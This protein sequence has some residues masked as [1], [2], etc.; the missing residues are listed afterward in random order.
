MTVGFRSAKNNAASNASTLTNTMP[1]GVAD[2][3]ALLL[4]LSMRG[5]TGSGCMIEPVVVCAATSGGGSVSHKRIVSAQ[6]GAYLY[7]SNYEDAQV[8]VV[9]TSDFVNTTDITVG[10]NPAW[11]FLSPDEANIYCFNMYGSS[12]SVIRTSDKTVVQTIS[13]SEHPYRDAAMTPDGAYLLCGHVTTGLTSLIRTS[14]GTVTYQPNVGSS[15]SGVVASPDSQYFYTSPRSASLYG[16]SRVK[17]SDG[18]VTQFT[19]GSASGTAAGVAISSDGAYVYTASSGRVQKWDTS[20]LAFH[21]YVV[22]RIEVVTA[23]ALSPD[24]STIFVGYIDALTAKISTAGSM[25]V[26]STSFQ[27]LYAMNFLFTPTGDYVWAR[28][29]Y[30]GQGSVRV[31]VSDGSSRG[32]AT[33]AT[34][35]FCWNNSSGS[36]LYANT[37]GARGIMKIETTD[38]GVWWRVGRSDGDATTLAQELFWRRALSEPASYTITFNASIYASSE[39]AAFTTA[40]AHFPTSQE[41]SQQINSSSTTISAAALGTWSSTDGYDV[42]FGG[43]AY[44]TTTTPPTNYT[45][46]A[47]GDSQTTGTSSG[48]STEVAYRALTGVTTVGALTATAVNAAINV[49]HHIFLTDG[50]L[51]SLALTLP[52]L[53]IDKGTQADTSGSTTLVSGN[54]ETIEM[55]SGVTPTGVTVQFDPTSVTTG[56]ST[57]ITIAVDN[58][59]TEGDSN[60]NIIATAPSMVT[61]KPV[62]VRKRNAPTPVRV[63]Q[64]PFN[65]GL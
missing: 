60:I 15:P 16:I 64:F 29:A 13:L 65:G 8:A 52:D 51:F 61:S 38:E 17:V 63:P 21:S 33:W 55:S 12:V 20:T 26:D 4:A 10:T 40:A 48:A 37:N 9:R 32:R 35:S 53:Q 46:P 28:S 3:D 25:S 7:R 44:Q 49:G 23:M 54:T 43:T 50:G 59:A 1:A 22:P 36:L 14:D 42:F 57:T 47:N 5:G 11:L 56:N 41:W 18:T 31:K 24:D 45:E 58:T 39:T 30:G 34:D 19:G 27:P 6:N 2:G 62:K